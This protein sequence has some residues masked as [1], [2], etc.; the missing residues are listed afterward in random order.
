MDGL[1]VVADSVPDRVIRMPSSP[2]SCLGNGLGNHRSKGNYWAAYELLFC[3]YDADANGVPIIHMAYEFVAIRAMG[4][5]W[6]SDRFA[7]R[8]LRM[9]RLRWFKPWTGRLRKWLA[10]M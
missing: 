1:R 5:A 8:L 3:K 10:E 7:G 4:R 6:L 9:A 2:G